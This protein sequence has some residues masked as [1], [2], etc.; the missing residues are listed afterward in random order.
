ML[1]KFR[2]STTVVGTTLIAYYLGIEKNNLEFDWLKFFGLALGGMLVVA[3]SN[4]FNQIYEKDTDEKMSRTK[5]RPLAANRMKVND[6][7]VFSSV[8]GLFGLLTLLFLVNGRCALISLISLF[9]YVLAYTP[10]KRV[11]PLKGNG[12]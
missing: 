1:S 6:A 5:N 7:I 11:S 10:L 12:G 4:G 9:I 3:S 2:L 8:C